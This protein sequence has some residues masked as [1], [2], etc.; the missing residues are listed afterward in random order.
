MVS[1]ETVYEWPHIQNH[2]TRLAHRE[3]EWVSVEVWDR[4]QKKNE[5]WVVKTGHRLTHTVV[6]I[7][8]KE[9][10]VLRVTQ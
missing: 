3:C 9:A 8:A 10:T 5:K 6:A 4:S 1:G 7:G 2:T